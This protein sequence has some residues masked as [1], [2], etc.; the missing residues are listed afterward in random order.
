MIIYL[1]GN[2]R[3]KLASYNLARLG[4]NRIF[5]FFYHAPGQDGGASM[6]W[7]NYMYG[8]KKRYLN[9]AKYK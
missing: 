5:S 1:G 2:M 4:S 3:N 6:D 9:I 7:D 8:V